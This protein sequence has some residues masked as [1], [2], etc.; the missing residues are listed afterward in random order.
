MGEILLRHS[1]KKK[2]DK[3]GKAQMDRIL[4][5]RLPRTGVGTTYCFRSRAK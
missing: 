2:K 4:L 5:C 1:R 3:Q